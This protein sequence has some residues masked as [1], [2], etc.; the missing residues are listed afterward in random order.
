MALDDYVAEIPTDAETLRGV[1]LAYLQDGEEIAIAD[2][3]PI[4]LI[5]PDDNPASENVNN[6]IW[7][8]RSARVI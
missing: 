4:R 7:S 8:V 6:W 2:G 1:L 3:G 5:F